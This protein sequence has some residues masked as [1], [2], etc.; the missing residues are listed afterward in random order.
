MHT[1]LQPEKLVYLDIETAPQCS[2]FDELTPQWQ[3]LW[4]HKSS[5]LQLSDP[6]ET[7]YQRAGIYAEFGKIICVCL[8]KLYSGGAFKIRCFNHPDEQ[9]LLQ[10]LSQWLRRNITSENK[11][12]AHNGKEFDFPWIARRMLIHGIQLP[13]CLNLAGKKPWEVPHIDT[14]ELWKFGDY[15]H[16]TSLNLLA[17]TFGI[18]SPKANFDGA[19]VGFQYWKNQ[20]IG[21]ITAYCCGDVKTLVQLVLKWAG[22]P[23]ITTV[24]IIS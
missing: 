4:A 2:E 20:A 18:P 19:Q 6:P 11:L 5:T 21:D 1:F 23:P 22:K 12:C 13:P 8:G 14:L 16:Y 15:K 10:Q 9:Q 24:E 17:E 7:T 3:A